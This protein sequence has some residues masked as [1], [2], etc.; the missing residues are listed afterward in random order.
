MVALYRTGN[1]RIDAVLTRA[2]GYR[3]QIQAKITAMMSQGIDVFDRQHK[4]VANTNPQKYTTAYTDAFAREFQSY[5]DEILTQIPGAVYALPIDDKGYLATHHA[6]VAKPLTGNY[7]VDLL[8]S[9]H[10]RIFFSLESEK[11]RA[12]NRTP[13]LLQT[14]MR[15][16]GE[17]LSEF[18][19]P[20]TIS[21]RHWGA[22]ILGLNPDQFLE[23]ES[24]TA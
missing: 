2:F 9:R 23:D 4:P 13:M 20:I 15:D 14:N 18:S 19:L 17:T 8:N 10:M 11:R 5:L 21:G 24:P 22:F 7:E 16:T 12:T 6:R 3:D 1:G